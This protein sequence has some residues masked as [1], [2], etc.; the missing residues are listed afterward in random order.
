MT[1]QAEVLVVPRGGSVV[2]VAARIAA[3]VAQGW[4]VGELRFEV[5]KP[6]APARGLVRP[7]PE[8]PRT[9]RTR[10]VKR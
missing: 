2:P 3:L 9:T 7:V 4:K 10:K 5:Y 1:E 6:V 8:L